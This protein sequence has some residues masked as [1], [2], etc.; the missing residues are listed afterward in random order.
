MSGGDTRPGVRSNVG[1]GHPGVRNK[2][3]GKVY[4]AAW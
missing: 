2:K 4:P 1:W 3:T